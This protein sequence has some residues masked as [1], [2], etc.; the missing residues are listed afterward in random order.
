[1]YSYVFQK[2]SKIFASFL[3]LILIRLTICDFY[4]FIAIIYHHHHPLQAITILLDSEKDIV[5]WN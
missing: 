5:G 3:I 4:T 2:L 1:M